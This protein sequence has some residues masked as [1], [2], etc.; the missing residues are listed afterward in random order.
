MK[1][2]IQINL[3]RAGENELWKTC[4]KIRYVMSVG[5]YIVNMHYRKLLGLLQIAADASRVA[6]ASRS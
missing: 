2:E 1:I 4:R 5:C 6:A 3:R